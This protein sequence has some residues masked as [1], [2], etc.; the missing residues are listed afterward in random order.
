ME[1]GMHSVESVSPLT[2]VPMTRPIALVAIRYRTQVRGWPD[3]P[4]W[5]DDI[6]GSF[7]LHI[8]KVSDIWVIL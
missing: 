5:R 8:F 3:I 7:S 1:S 6:T 4:A 2:V